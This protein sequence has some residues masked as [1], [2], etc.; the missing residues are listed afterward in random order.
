SQSS[1][2]LTLEKGAYR[3]HAPAPRRSPS[4]L[5]RGHV[6]RDVWTA[7]EKQMALIVLLLVLAT[8]T[9]FGAAYYLLVTR[10]EHKVLQAEVSASDSH[11]SLHLEVVPFEPDDLDGSSIHPDTKFLSY[12]PHSG[13]H[14]QRIAFENAL[15]LARILNRT[16]LVPPVRLAKANGTSGY[17]PFDALLNYTIHA[18]KQDLIHCASFS[19]YATLPTE[20]VNYFDYTL[21]SW[22]WIVDL[23]SI[24]AEQDI[25]E[26][27][28]F[29]DEWIQQHLHI[30]ED[31]T[32][33]L[34]DD[35][36]Y[37]YRFVD[38]HPQKSLGP[39]YLES[40]SIS[41]LNKHPHR[42]LQIGTL[43]GSSRL[44][45][46]DSWNVAIRT[47][48]REKMVFANPLFHEITDAVQLSLGGAY[49]AAH[50]RVGDGHFTTNARENVRVIWQRLVHNS[51][52]FST[53]DLA[54]NS[55]LEDESIL[56]SNFAGLD[57]LLPELSPSSRKRT[58]THLRCQRPPHTDPHLIPLNIPLFISTDAPEPSAHEALRLFYDTFPCTF[59]LSDVPEQLAL[60]DNLQSGYDGLMLRD[61]AI[62]FLDAMV[63]A[64]ADDVV[65]TEGSTFSQ[66]VEDVL[67]MQYHGWDIVQRG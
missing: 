41:E 66:F 45:L 43:F 54:N 46:R 52:G 44:R 20:C 59:T 10:W 6:P 12:L 17:M 7:P 27:W 56:P 36:A 5:R 26:R 60:L 34:K 22:D 32:L 18:G 14:N 50:V 57:A 58:N 30:S 3:M 55:I 42:L 2:S 16:L 38:L 63:A 37:H 62:P 19:S 48:V 29:H 21:V 39:R 13:F 1:P 9:C 11:E 40:I 49:L 64:K 28:D 15:V 35:N 31:E 53:N 23:D 8:L 24:R 65:G 47:D 61:F 4:K 33:I 67:W 51:L 25:L